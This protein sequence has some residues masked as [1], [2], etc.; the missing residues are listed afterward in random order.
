MQKLNGKYD[1]LFDIDWQ[2]ARSL[3]RKLGKLA[4]SIFILPPSMEELE[5]RLRLRGQD[6]E[7]S[8][9]TRLEVAHF[10]MSKH[11]LYDYVLIN[12]DFDETLQRIGNIIST[13]RVRHFNFDKFV[14][15]LIK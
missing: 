12:Q 3:K 5:K 9:E 10:E 2:G 11:H 1:V 14:E 8:I 15:N 13:E 6:S 4:V 7:K